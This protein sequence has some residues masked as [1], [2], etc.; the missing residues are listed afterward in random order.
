MRAGDRL[1]GRSRPAQ[2]SL[3]PTFFEDDHLAAGLVLE[4]QD[5]GPGIPPEQRNVVF[6]RFARLDTAHNKETGGTGLGLPIAKE[7][8]AQHG[9]TLRIEDSEQGARFVVR[10]PIRNSQWRLTPLTGRHL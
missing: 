9:G 3:T 4:V 2:P 6:E 5:D 8:A 10:I 1:S 7:I